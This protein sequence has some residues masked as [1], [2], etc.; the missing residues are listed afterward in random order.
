M[1]LLGQ[2]ATL[3]YGFVRPGCYIALWFC[4]ARLLHC[5]MVLLGQAATLLYGFVRPGC[6]IALWF[7]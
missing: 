4:K 6:Y 7:C 3:L 2:V 5:S 1:V